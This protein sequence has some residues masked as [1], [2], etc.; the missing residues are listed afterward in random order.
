MREFYYRSGQP[1]L[2]QFPGHHRSRRGD[3]GHEFRSHVPLTHAPDARRLDLLAS[4]RDPLGQW[5]VRLASERK[6]IPVY[7]VADL[8]ASMGYV[9]ERRR[10]DVLADF[11]ESLAWSAWRTGDPFGFVGCDERVRPDWV[12]P[13]VRSRGAGSQLAQ[14]LRGFVPTGRSAIG[15]AD[16]HRMLRRQRS[17]VFL[18]SDFHLPLDQ[19][20]RVLDSLSMHE[21]VPV[22]LWDR[23][24][25][26]P[27]PARSGL[28]PLADAES[29]R[30]R[31]LWL[32]P[33][34]RARWVERIEARQDALDALFRRHRLRPL[35]LVDGFDAD[36]VTA[37]FHR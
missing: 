35:R 24:E 15:L 7:A 9:G 1:A 36:A 26:E 29:G 21:I 14:R 20:D 12:Q 19:L 10:L 16:A 8:S 5:L 34:L 18:L 25:F 32:R 31:L 33:A 28:A 13:P 27:P 11:T 17:L 2:G 6:A 23:G 4:L 22:L 3:S 37:H 30:Q